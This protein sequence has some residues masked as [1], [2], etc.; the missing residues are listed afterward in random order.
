MSVLLE[1]NCPKCD[2]RAVS[3]DR[4]TRIQIEQL[5]GLMDLQMAEFDE[6]I[7]SGNVFLMKEL[8]RSIRELARMIDRLKFS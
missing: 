4:I 8:L 3:N 7:T 6:A 5:C 1:P 2:R